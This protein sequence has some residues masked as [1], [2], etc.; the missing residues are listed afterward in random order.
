MDQLDTYYRALSEYRK[1]TAENV[2]CG[3]LCAAIAR[4]GA[5]SECIE[6]TTTFCSIEEDWIEEIEKGLVHVEKAIAEERQFVRSN[7]EVLPIEKVKRVSKDSVEHL[8]RHS[9]LLTKAAD[10]RERNVLPDHLYTVE[11]LSDYAVYENRFLYMLLCYLRDFV[12]LR[13][14]KIVELTNAYNGK[15]TISKAVSAGK[16][17]ISYRFELS[18]ERRGDRF[19]KE[20]N[21]QRETIARIDRILK[22]VMHYLSTPLMEQV[23]KAAMLKPPVTKTNVL[24]MNQNFKGAMALYEFVSSYKKAGYTAERKS[25]RLSPLP[26]ETAEEFAEAAA[27]VSFL[28]YEHGLGIEG[29]LKE[30]YEEEEKR[31]KEEESRR[32]AEQIRNL[33]G[34]IRDFGVSAEEYMLLLEKRNRSLEEDSAQ[35]VRAKREIARWKEETDVW[36]QT[37]QEREAKIGK[38]AEEIGLLNRKYDEDTAALKREYE[39]RTAE[40]EEANRSERERL[41]ATHA[42]EMASYAA[43]REDELTALKLAHREETDALKAALAEE[44]TQAEARAAELKARFADERAENRRAFEEEKA[45]LEETAKEKERKIAALEAEAKRAE[46]KNAVSAARIN[47]LRK[48]CG[49]PTGE[50]EFTSPEAFDE[51][52]REYKA[53]KELFKREWKRAKKKIRK[54]LFSSESSEPKE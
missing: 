9:N 39:E 10:E 15:A 52:E 33:K 19:L 25:K 23:S 45:R 49:L 6:V 1:Q 32:L 5:D 4:A 30:S 29:I 26:D 35:L 44:K 46:E 28:T 12:G 7:G 21:A 36:K 48:E 38:Q 51:L 20:H 17:K 27:L 31:R 42:Q 53:F 37:A 18:E 54:E 2:E 22:T 50:D 11:R 3:R 16:R 24:K 8:A 34:R 13:Y 41:Q 40:M 14:Q 47:A 43:A